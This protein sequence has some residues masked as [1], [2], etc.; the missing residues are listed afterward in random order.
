[1]DK[2]EKIGSLESKLSSLTEEMNNLKMVLSVSENTK[3]ETVD[4][5]KQVHN[6]EIESLRCVLQDSMEEQRHELFHEFE[7][8]RRRWEDEKNSFVKQIENHK[9]EN[10]VMNSSIN[11]G[12]EEMDNQMKQAQFEAEKLRTVVLPLEEEILQLKKKLEEYRLKEESTSSD[13]RKQ[14][15]DHSNTTETTLHQDSSMQNQE[16]QSDATSQSQATQCELSIPTTQQANEDLTPSHRVNSAPQLNLKTDQTAPVSSNQELSNLQVDQTEVDLWK[17]KYE[18]EKKKV[19]SYN[20]L[21]KKSDELLS[22][23]NEKL[24]TLERRFEDERNWR[25]KKET[26]DNDEIGKL[27]KNRDHIKDAYISLKREHDSLRKLVE[28]HK[29]EVDYTMA[30][31]PAATPEVYATLTRYKNAL[32]AAN[33]EKAQKETKLLSKINFLEQT[34]RA[35]QVAK[36]QIENA[37]SLELEETRVQLASFHSIQSQLD[38]ETKERSDLETALEEEKLNVHAIRSKSRNIIKDIREK[39]ILEKELNKGLQKDLDDERN[40]NRSLQGS[41]ETSEQVQRDFVQLSQSLQ[42]QLEELRSKNESNSESS[43]QAD[44]DANL[45]PAPS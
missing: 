40:K 13:K 11:K 6:Q 1:M 42:M 15:D 24:D 33:T 39:L 41:L 12:D 34:L 32:I 38:K 43:S 27:V 3:Q 20:D 8:E 22:G 16:T 31:P 9:K 30:V 17:I 10:E 35:E 28:K 5:L 45:T 18:E 44:N 29:M 26:A 21:K 19:I 2:D 36:E 37:L 7:R 23:L 25:L 4:E 14:C